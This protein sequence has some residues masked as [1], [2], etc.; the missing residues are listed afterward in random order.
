VKI[1]SEGLMA[2]RV[3][4]EVHRKTEA[5]AKAL[6]Q[7]LCDYPTG[8]SLPCV[9]KPTEPDRSGDHRFV[10]EFFDLSEAQVRQLVVAV[11]KLG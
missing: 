4:P 7:E 8:P 11:K 5:R 1:D 6:S 9:I 2:T 10:V 3:L